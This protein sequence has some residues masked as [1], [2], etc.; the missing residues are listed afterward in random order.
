MTPRDIEKLKAIGYH[1]SSD[2]NGVST[3]WFADRGYHGMP[4][5]ICDSEAEAWSACKTHAQSPEGLKAT[6]AD[7]VRWL[8]DIGVRAL[9]N[10][11]FEARSYLVKV[12]GASPEAAVDALFWKVP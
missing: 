2:F 3:H 5:T 7:K 6:M 10:G 12:E 8:V 9:P 4:A 1:V 11:H